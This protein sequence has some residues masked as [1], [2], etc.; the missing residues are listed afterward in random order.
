MRHQAT[1]Q[2]CSSGGSK[3]IVKSMEAAMGKQGTAMGLM[4]RIFALA[5]LG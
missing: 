4:Q 3:E 1:I 2:P 5:L